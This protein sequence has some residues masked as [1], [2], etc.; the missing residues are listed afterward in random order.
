[1]NAGYVEKRYLE[2]NE[3]TARLFVT[4]KGRRLSNIHKAYDVADISQTTAYLVER[5][6][7]A[8]LDA[9]Y[10]VLEEYLNLLKSESAPS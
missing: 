10:R 9:F 5:C 2:N 3:K 8:D 4:E 1:M 7:E 6:S